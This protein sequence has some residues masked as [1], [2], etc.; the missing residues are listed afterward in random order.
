MTYPGRI[1]NLSLDDDTKASLGIVSES[2]VPIPQLTDSQNMA[3]VMM[4][5]SEK[6]LRKQIVD[7]LK[8]ERKAAGL[9]ETPGQEE[10][11]WLKQ[12]GLAQRPDGA[13]WMRLTRAGEREAMRAALTFARRLCIHVPLFSTF[14]YDE[15]CRCSCGTFS[16]TARV[17]GT[18][19]LMATRRS[20]SLHMDDVESGAWAKGQAA[21]EEMFGTGT[22]SSA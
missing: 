15:V 18:Q 3:L 16:R 8:A 9:F 6:E 19:N 21:I 7:R 2:P 12:Q 11:A 5:W 4:L 13:Q 10:F 1:S 20:F 17:F 22:G 14:G